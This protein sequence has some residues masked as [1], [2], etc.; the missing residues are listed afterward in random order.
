MTRGVRHYLWLHGMFQAICQE[1][2]H[3][4]LPAAQSQGNAVH[5]CQHISAHR[6]FLILD[7]V[8]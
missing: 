4:I 6:E 3:F 1:I 8:K 7:I 5:G 2:R